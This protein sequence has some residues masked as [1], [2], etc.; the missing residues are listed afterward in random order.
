MQITELLNSTYMWTYLFH[1]MDHFL[2]IDVF[3][4]LQYLQFEEMM[5]ILKY[6]NI[7]YMY[8]KTRLVL[9]LC[10]GNIISW[11]IQ[12]VFFMSID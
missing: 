6:Y 11:F 3:N 2:A 1:L 10:T 4:I 9:H 8:G 12:C 7:W 5:R